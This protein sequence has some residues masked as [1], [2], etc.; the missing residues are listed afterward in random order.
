MFARLVETAM[1]VGFLW[2]TYWAAGVMEHYLDVPRQGMLFVVICL[3]ISRIER[4]L[5][6]KIGGN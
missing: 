6:L 3:A 4:K 1:E 2:G 5:S